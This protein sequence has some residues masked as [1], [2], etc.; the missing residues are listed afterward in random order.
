[1]R[2]SIFILFAICLIGQ[3]AANAQTYEV[4]RGYHFKTPEDYARYEA[5]VIRTADWMQQT[6]WTTQPE[7]REAATQFFLSWI[8]GTPAVTV[9]LTET[10]MNLSDRNPQLGF[11]YMAQYA[12][13]VLLH[14]NEESN[15]KPA[16]EALKAVIDKY[17]SEPSHKRDID[18]DNLATLEKDGRLADFVANEF[19]NE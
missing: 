19:Y 17:R 14:R 15:I 18:V 3:L 8:K 9:K 1:M 13:Y 16:I 10:V 4:P 6:S 11:T 2:R 12:K 7:K 5:D